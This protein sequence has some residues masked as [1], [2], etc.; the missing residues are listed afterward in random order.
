MPTRNQIH[1]GNPK[2]WCESLHRRRQDN[3]IEVGDDAKAEETPPALR[4]QKAMTEHPPG[5]RT[6]DG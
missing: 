1:P 4:G 5:H 2:D 6:M 3:A